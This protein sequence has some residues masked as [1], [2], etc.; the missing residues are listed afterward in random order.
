MV[1]A[2]EVPSRSG[3]GPSSPPSR[4]R[5]ASLAPAAA[6]AQVATLDGSPLNVYADGL[7]ALQVRYDGQASG[8]V[9][10]ARREPGARRPGDQGGRRLLR[11]RRRGR[12]RRA[13]APAAVAAAGAG[14]Q[15][16]TSTYTV[17][18]DLQVAETLTYANGTDVR[19]RQLRRDEHLRRA[20]L[21]PRG[22]ARRPLRGRQRQRQ[23]RRLLGRRRASSAGATRQTG[24]VVG[25]VEQTPWLDFQEGNF[26]DRVRRV[27]GER[28]STARSTRR[29]RTTASASSGRSRSRAGPDAR[30]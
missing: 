17:G 16:I 26:A 7:G 30:R 14:A 24:L 28:A 5:S 15:A 10:P 25:L 23:R 27:R 3:R 2:R 6:R 29:T 4:P 18:P 8:R 20:G 13:V 12:A 21:V 19:G 22:R 9:L 11:P 1:C